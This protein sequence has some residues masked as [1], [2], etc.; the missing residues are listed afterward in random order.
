MTTIRELRARQRAENKANLLEG[1]ELNGWSLTPTA[2]WLGVR[3]SYLEWM[4]AYHGLASEYAKRKHPHTG[5]PP[6]KRDPDEPPKASEQQQ[7]APAAPERK[8][9]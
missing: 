7:P 2:R 3:I 9:C 1:L 8:P 5:R 4:I 6:R